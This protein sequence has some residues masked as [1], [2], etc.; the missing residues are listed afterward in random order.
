MIIKH[1]RDA[2]FAI[3][4]VPGV[5]PFHSPPDNQVTRGRCQRPSAR[6]C[7]HA[8]FSIP[9]KSK[10]AL[11]SQSLPWNATAMSVIPNLL[12]HFCI[13]VE[14][15]TGFQQVIYTNIDDT[16]NDSGNCD[17]KKLLIL[18]VLFFC[19]EHFADDH[20]ATNMYFCSRLRILSQCGYGE[21]FGTGKT[22]TTMTKRFVEIETEIN[23][24]I[25]N[26]LLR[27]TQQ[28][29]PFLDN[30]SRYR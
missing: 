18:R 2:C 12:L 10:F 9:S 14:L 11:T 30:T 26:L 1:L 8:F 6:R 17:V 21:D 4:I 5:V 3:I 15:P 29:M 28:T 22:T 19:S 27:F 23:N 13:Y 16:S 25:R 7:S 24:K 20:T